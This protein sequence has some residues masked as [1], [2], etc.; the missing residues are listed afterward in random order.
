MDLLYNTEQS[1]ITR[2]ECDYME[3]VGVSHKATCLE[4]MQ[5]LES[6]SATSVLLGIGLNSIQNSCHDE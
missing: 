4:H 6:S 3:P 1:R 5:Q 2:I